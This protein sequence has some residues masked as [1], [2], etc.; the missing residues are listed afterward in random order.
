MDREAI[1]IVNWNACS[2]KSKNIEF[3]DFLNEWNIGIAVITETHLKPEL[4]VDRTCSGGGG[5]AVDRRDIIKLTRLRQNFIIA[6]DLNAKHQAWSNS[7]RN[8]NGTILYN[9]LQEAHYNILCPYT[10]TWLSRSGAHATIDIFISNIDDNISQP[11]AYSKTDLGPLSG[12]G[13]SRFL[14]Q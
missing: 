7:R 11:I 4:N 1:K 13:R 6:G 14:T 9:D 3:V 5:V 8:H 12:G 10:P 2:L